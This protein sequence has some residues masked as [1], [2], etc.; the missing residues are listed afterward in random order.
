MIVRFDIERDLLAGVIDVAD[1]PAAWDAAM[2]DLL[3]IDTT[4]NYRD[5][6]MQ[7]VHWFAGLI[8]YFPCYTLGAVAAAQLYAGLKR[9]QPGIEVHIRKGDFAPLR[10]WLR[11]EVHGQ[12]RLL[13]GLEVVTQATGRALDTR[14][15]LQHLLHRYGGAAA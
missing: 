1:I 13:D 11:R 10:A 15:Y 4:G 3:G 7:D 9:A 12:G 5:G 8:G 2:K 14:D 6:C